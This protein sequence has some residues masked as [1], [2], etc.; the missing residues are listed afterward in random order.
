MR[1]RLARTIGGASRWVRPARV[2]FLVLALVIGGCIAGEVALYRWITAAA[3]P[4]TTIVQAGA[5][6]RGPVRLASPLDV[7]WQRTLAS[8]NRVDD[9]W[10]R[11]LEP[12]L[13]PA[14]C[15]NPDPANDVGAAITAVDAAIARGAVRDELQRRIGDL[16]A[17]AVFQA[18]TEAEFLVRYNLARG[19]VAAGD[20][21][22]AAETVEPIFDGFLNGDRLP[23]AN[24][25]A[26]ERLV[27]NDD[28][29]TSAAGLGF[30]ARFLAGKIAYE[31]GD[32]HTAIKHFRLAINAVNYL[33]AERAPDGLTAAGHYQR[34]PVGLGTHACAP[35]R[36]A[37][38]TSLD[39]YAGLVAAYLAAPDFTDRG[40]LAPEVSR[41]RFQIDPDD[42]FRPVLRYAASAA[43]R[44]R[45]GAI[46][47]NVLWAASNL[48]RVYHYNRLDPDP[49]LEVTRA[50]LLLHLT[51]NDAWVD[52]IAENGEGDVC[53]MLNGIGEQ[54][55]REASAGAVRGRPAA[56][57]ADSARAA[58]ALHAY[59]RLAGRCTSW[60]VAPVE[61]PVRSAWIR[62]GGALVGAEL[63][64]LYD[65]WRS[66]LERALERGAAGN[67]LQP[68]LARVASHRRTFAGGRVPA[69]LPATIAPADGRAFV[70]TWWRAVYADVAAALVDVA[71][72]DAGAVTAA[73][74]PQLLSVLHSA[75]RHAGVR[76]SQLYARRDLEPL[77]R[78]GG[79]AA[80]MRYRFRYAA[81]DNPAA[82][83]VLLGVAFTLVVALALAAHVNVWRYDL[84][85]RRK[86]F[87][88]ESARRRR[89]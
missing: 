45:D 51:S 72:R 28:V 29:S 37:G 24:F 61:A 73:R 50:V 68:V 55:H 3:D 75:Q 52:A 42:P 18:G 89:S 30:H 14:I 65:A 39:A 56:A 8:A 77:A 87:Q 44:A 4:A 63:P 83:F 11:L 7:A 32:V 21:S 69:D 40:R 13:P 41:S 67:T 19:Y 49:R 22:T 26:A 34:L 38:V 54:L 58:V 1:R 16:R 80:Y 9:D 60:D 88:A 25:N 10:R 57:A 15:P 59:A 23:A 5:L 76:P 31:R 36:G 47:E 6:L 12:P 79:D 2:S 46:P 43:G 81:L 85:T 74:A 71:T 33:L 62:A 86:L 84:L 35:A 78:A 82:M 27:A 66:E 64:A 70:D 48:Q 53:A 20:A 17:A